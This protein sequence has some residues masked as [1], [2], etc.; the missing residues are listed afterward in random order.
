LKHLAE[1]LSVAVV[2]SLA[3]HS[4]VISALAGPVHER[5]YSFQTIDPPYGEPGVVLDVQI[6]WMNNAGMI[7]V[8]YQSPIDPDWLTNMHTVVLWRGEWTVIDVPGAF[9]TGGTNANNNGQVAL[10]YVYEDGIWHL[11]IYDDG[12]LT[13][14]PDLP[15]YPGGIIAQAINERGQLAATIIDAEGIWHALVGDASNYE[16]F[17]YPDPDVIDTEAFGINNAGVAVGF[18]ILVDGSYH[19]LTYDGGNLENIDHPDG[20]GSFG[21]SINNRGVILGA[22]FNQAWELIPFLLEDG[23]YTDFLVPDALY[24]EPYFI[25][26]RGQ[27]SGAYADIN[28]VRH[29]FV[30]TPAAGRP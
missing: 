12:E 22:Y 9:S 16:V 29:G 3:A 10:S 30:A 4:L 20:L 15:E 19:A 25:N 18:Y 21:V 24:T 27:I 6:V 1:A 5:G 14:F 7:T 2:V 28:G 11:A 23:R 13:P 26:D 17:D 8:Q